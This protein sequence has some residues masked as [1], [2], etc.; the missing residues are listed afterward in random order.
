MKSFLIIDPVT[1]KNHLD[2]E[3][4]DYLVVEQVLTAENID[5]WTDRIRQHIR[6]VW[7][8]G[9]DKEG[10]TIILD[11]GPQYSVILFTLQNNM[12]KEEGI[13]FVIGLD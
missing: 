13:N 8:E 1:K 5:S 3:V 12:L 10:L 4:S 6:K 2:Q 11:T 7:N 9:G